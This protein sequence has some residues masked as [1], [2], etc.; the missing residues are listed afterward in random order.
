MSVVAV[1]IQQAWGSVW[2]WL[3]VSNAHQPD[4]DSACSV[5]TTSQIQMISLVVS[6]HSLRDGKWAI[7][8]FNIIVNQWRFNVD[9]GLSNDHW[10]V[11]MRTL[12]APWSTFQCDNALIDGKCKA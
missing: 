6:L 3:I 8:V 5:R 7:Q 10:L 2:P 1:V 4:G 12:F 9:E 11:I